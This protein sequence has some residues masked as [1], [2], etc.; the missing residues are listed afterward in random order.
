LQVSGSAP[1][2]LWQKIFVQGIIWNV[3]SYDQ[4]GLELD[5]KLAGAILPKLRVPGDVSSHDS[6]TDGPPI[7]R[8]QEGSGSAG[9]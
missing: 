2:I 9:G 7:K 3:N 8:R 5:K 1:S 4:R 6:S